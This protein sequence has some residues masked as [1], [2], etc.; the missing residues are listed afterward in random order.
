MKR[1][2]NYEKRSVQL[3]KGCK[4]LG[5]ALKRRRHRGGDPGSSLDPVRNAKCDYCGGRPVGGSATWMSGALQEE[6]HWWC[7]QCARDLH[8][9]DAKPENTLPEDVDFEDQELVKKLTLQMEEIEKR[10]DEFIRRKVS[11]RKGTA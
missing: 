6:A 2:V 1:L 4:D 10:R 5:D 3:P 11:E 8:E 7:E 9:F